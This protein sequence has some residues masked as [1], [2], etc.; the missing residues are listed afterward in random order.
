MPASDRLTDE[1]LV[2]RCGMPPFAANPLNRACGQHEGVY[3]FSVQAKAF[4]SFEE[5]ASWCRNNSV[6]FTSVGEIRKMGYDVVV[7]S[8][9]GYHATVVVPIDWTAEAAELLTSLFQHA[10][11]PAPKRRP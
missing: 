11:N 4:V 1:S 2:V 3:G 7:T 9:A 6:G 10:K 5:L 8:G